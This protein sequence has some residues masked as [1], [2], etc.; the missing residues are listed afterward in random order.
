MRTMKLLVMA[1][2]VLITAIGLV[3]V[4]APSALLEIGRSLQTTGA[5]YA[6]AVVRVAIGALLL[7]VASA[8]RM[9]RTLRAVGTIIIVA[10]LVTPV[11]EVERAQAMLNWWSN[12]GQLLMRASA[13]IAVALGL[14]I[15][16]VVT[17]RRRAA[18]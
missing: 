10:G 15:V 2:G 12:Q 5:L 3:G 1:L 9:P 8:S 13:G 4:A 7:S 17:T 18:A 11:I 14:F 6:V 16:Y